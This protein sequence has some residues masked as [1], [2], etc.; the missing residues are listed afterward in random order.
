[1]KK[2]TIYFL[3]CM[4][5][6]AGIVQ[7]LYADGSSWRNSIVSFLN[8]NKKLI[9]Y[10]SAA[11]LAAGLGYIGYRKCQKK[12]NEPKNMS[13]DE[14]QKKCSA[15]PSYEEVYPDDMT[16]EERMKIIPKDKALEKIEL[17]TIV[18][19]FVAHEEQYLAEDQKWC[20]M[21]REDAKRSL[22]INFPFAQ[23]LEAKPGTQITIAFHGDLHGDVHSLLECINN[24]KQKGYMNRQNP[25]K[26][27]APN[28]RMVFLGDYVDRGL[29]GAEVIYTILRLKLAN[30]DKVFLVRGNHEDIDINRKHGFAQ[31]LVNKFNLQEQEAYNYLKKVSGIY[32]LMPVVLY[33]GNNN[34][35]RK[36]KNFIQCCH[37]GM[38]LGYNP[39]Q[40]LKS[41]RQYQLLGELKIKDNFNKLVDEQEKASIEKIIPVAKLQNVIP[42]GPMTRFNIENKIGHPSGIPCS[43]GAYTYGLGHLWNDF[44]VDE[45]GDDGRLIAYRDDRG[46]ICGK[47]FTRRILA[48]HSSESCKVH[49]V[50][51]AHQHS[52]NPED[53][54]MMRITNADNKGHNCDKGCGKIWIPEGTDPEETKNL[55]EGIVCTFSVAPHTPYKPALR[56]LGDVYGLLTI[57]PSEFEDWELE[58]VRLN[59]QKGKDIQP[60]RTEVRSNLIKVGY[61]QD[62]A[63]RKERA[64]KN[65]Y[66]LTC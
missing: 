58:M 50:M 29:Y 45:I 53:P 15:L 47:E 40:L 18:E 9:G 31:E 62:L 37:G 35:E 44:M 65:G 26:I 11:L 5:L 56:G 60:T 49:G 7:P 4:I 32:D 33:V 19:D 2:L 63:A 46:L 55:W 21:R 41:D 6:F 66:A 34:G 52:N 1:M 30:P 23:K 64:I 27:A 48:Q 54:M 3:S 61:E 43:N 8:E 25:F 24:L 16:R 59:E 17:E 57:K 38:E 28:F 12:E 13:F 42:I 51:R 20:G 14:W 39:Q 22:R 10:G 36:N